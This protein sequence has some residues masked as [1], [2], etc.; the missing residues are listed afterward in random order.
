MSTRPV[1]ATPSSGARSRLGCDSRTRQ[2]ANGP[3]GFL[4]A[5]FELAAKNHCEYHS[6]DFSDDVLV[7][8]NS[9][10]QYDPTVYEIVGTEERIASAFLLSHVIDIPAGTTHARSKQP[11]RQ[12]HARSRMGEVE[13]DPHRRRSHARLRAR[14][15]TGRG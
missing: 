3:A 15:E 6:N 10:L 7:K 2:P 13:D 5:G 12:H 11:S 9:P 1:S 4:G 8:R 14:N